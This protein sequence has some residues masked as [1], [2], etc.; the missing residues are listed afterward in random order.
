MRPRPYRKVV[1]ELIPLCAAKGLTIESSPD[2]K[3]SHRSLTF[4]NLVNG[5]RAPVVLSGNKEISPVVQRGTLA[6]L[7][8]RSSEFPVGH[9]A[10]DHS[11]QVRKIL[12]RYFNS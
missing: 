5:Q 4:V 10:R 3:G 9:P 6:Y 2:G 8:R 7:A 12:E 1:S 11:E